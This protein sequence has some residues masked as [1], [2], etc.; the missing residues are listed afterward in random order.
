MIVTIDDYRGAANT[1][2]AGPKD[3][4]DS[5]RFTVAKAGHL[6]MKLQ[7][8]NNMLTRTPAHQHGELLYDVIL[9]SA[10]PRVYVNGAEEVYFLLKHLPWPEKIPKVFVK[11]YREVL[12]S[13]PFTNRYYSNFLTRE[14]LKHYGPLSAPTF[15]SVR[16]LLPE[17]D[18]LCNTSLSDVFRNADDRCLSQLY[19]SDT[20]LTDSSKTFPLHALAC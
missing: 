2:E 8:L 4:K 18:A 20:L 3:E 1:N 9:Q 17:I 15:S 12:Q 19:H 16:Q 5:F 10:P 7:A 13:R 6:K 14:E 11:A